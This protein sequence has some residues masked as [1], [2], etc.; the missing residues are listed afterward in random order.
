MFSSMP[1]IDERGSCSEYFLL[2]INEKDA[3]NF[4]G[5]QHRSPGI[6]HGDDNAEEAHQ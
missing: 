4:R 3:S 6:G 1:P 5:I 2:L